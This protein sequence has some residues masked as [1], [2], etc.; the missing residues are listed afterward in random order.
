MNDDTELAV[1]AERVRQRVG[2]LPTFARM[3]GPLDPE[4]WLVRL[5]AAAAKQEAEIR[6][7]GP[8][9]FIELLMIAET[10]YC[11]GCDG[12]A[13]TCRIAEYIKSRNKWRLS[14]FCPKCFGRFVGAIPIVKDNKP[15]GEQRVYIESEPYILMGKSGQSFVMARCDCKPA[16]NQYGVKCE[17]S[18]TA[19]DG[20]CA[21]RRWFAEHAVM[22]SARA[23]WR[24]EAQ[25]TNV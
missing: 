3:T 12:R 9:T 13:S 2:A 22:D 5:N 8:K 19:A 21:V 16:E 1:T 11:P 23:R 18:P 6:A 25:A 20:L 24:R 14:E 4:A 10:K 15:A 7:R 17:V